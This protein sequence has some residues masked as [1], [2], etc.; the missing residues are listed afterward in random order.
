VSQPRHR[1]VVVD[2]DVVSYLFKRDSRAES[3]RPHLEA[4]QLVLSFMSLAELYR[5]TLRRRWGQA[6][7]QRLEAHLRNFT[8]YP[9]DRA[10]CRQWAEVT[11]ERQQAGRPIAV[12]DAWIAATALAH[13]LPLVTHNPDDFSGVPDLVVISEAG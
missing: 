6:R 11:E 9:F 1:A 4:R 12:A 2:T 3:Y 13:D 5:W 8:V 10:L 7:R